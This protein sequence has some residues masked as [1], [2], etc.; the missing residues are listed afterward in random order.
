MISALNNHKSIQKLKRITY[1]YYHFLVFCDYRCCFLCCL[2]RFCQSFWRYYFQKRNSFQIQNE[3]MNLIIALDSSQGRM[4]WTFI[5]CYEAVWRL[6]SHPNC[7]FSEIQ[8]SLEQSNYES[9]L[10]LLM[11]HQYMKDRIFCY[12]RL[13]GMAFKHS[14]NV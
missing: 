14:T 5:G 6:A 9:I 10:F 4:F 7:G 11:S 13:N 3:Q 2:Y 12:N 1:G 8:I